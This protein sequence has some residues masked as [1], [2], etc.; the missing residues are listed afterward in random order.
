M[1]GA[2]KRLLADINTALSDGEGELL[3]GGLFRRICASLGLDAKTAAVVFDTSVPNTRRWLA[4]EVVPPAANLVLRF[5]VEELQ[6][7]DV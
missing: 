3:F 7:T 2:R 4:G 6:K 5:S 1:P